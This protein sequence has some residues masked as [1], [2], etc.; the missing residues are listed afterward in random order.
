M[1]RLRAVKI[2]GRLYQT[3]S[4][5][6]RRFTETPYKSSLAFTCLRV[7]REANQSQLEKSI[8]QKSQ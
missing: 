5:L 4:Q 2:V 1:R 7:N 8:S 6:N 3:P